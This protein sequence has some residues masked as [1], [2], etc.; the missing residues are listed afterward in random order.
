MSTAIPNLLNV[1]EAAQHLRCSK[2]LV[3]KLSERRD[4]RHFKVGNRLL[5]DPDDLNAFLRSQLRE[6][7]AS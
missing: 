5:F 6:V 2:S 4:L 3:Y 7:E 1:T